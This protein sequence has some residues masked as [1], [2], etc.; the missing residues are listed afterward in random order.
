MPFLLVTGKFLQKLN[1][2][3]FNIASKISLSMT[4]REN[5][6]DLLCEEKCR[7]SKPN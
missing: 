7:T 2:R 3:S 6:V 5:S 1:E 4:H